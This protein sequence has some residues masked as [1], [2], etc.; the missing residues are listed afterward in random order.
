MPEP[1]NTHAD[2]GTDSAVHKLLDAARTPGDRQAA[3]RSLDFAP[4]TRYRVIAQPASTTSASAGPSAV[5]T[6]V[7]GA[8]R[9]EIL[10]ST[11]AVGAPRAGTV[12][13]THLTLPT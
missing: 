9:A 2:S 3:A 8:V 5:F 6:T 4:T 1:S 7:V 13:Y 11:N 12:S 10:L